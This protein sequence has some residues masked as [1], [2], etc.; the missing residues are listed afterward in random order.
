M[1]TYNFFRQNIQPEHLF[2]TSHSSKLPNQLFKE[3]KSSLIC[4]GEA[5][6]KSNV[7]C[8]CSFIDNF[9]NYYMQI[10]FVSDNICFQQYVI[11]VARAVRKTACSTI[12]SA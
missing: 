8:T 11:Y 6:H 12:L 9:D 10:K 2:Q 3:S 4:F 5:Q 1:P 7:V